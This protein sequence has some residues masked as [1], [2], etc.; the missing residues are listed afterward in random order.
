MSATV[1]LASTHGPPDADSLPASLSAA[2]L[3]SQWIDLPVDRVIVRVGKVELG[4]G[5][6]TALAQIAAEELDVALSRITML[7]ASTGTSPD[8][9]VTSGSR[10]IMDSGSALR[11]VCSQARMLFLIAAAKRCG[12]AAT[13]LSV[14]DGN[15]YDSRG[16]L[17]ASYWQL[18]TADLLA[19]PVTG[20][21]K[22]KPPANHQVVGDSA[23]RLDL[24]DKLAGRPRFIH[25][26]VEPGQL[27]GRVLRPPSPAAHLLELDEG[28][29]LAMP[30]VVRIVRRA[31]FLG[32]IAERE[33]QA[34]QAVEVLR[35]NASWSPQPPLPDQL[36]LTDYLKSQPSQE[37]PIFR[38]PG[39]S[40]I[41][42]ATVPVGG[43]VRGRYTRPYLAHASIAPSAAMARWHGDQVTVWTHSQGIYLLRAAI[44]DACCLAIDKVL[45]KHVEG[46]GCYGHNGA[47]DVA[48]DAVLLAA[49]VPDRPVHVVWS[50]DDEFAWEPYGSAMVAELRVTTDDDGDLVGWQQDI[51]SNGHHSR[52]GYADQPGLLADWHSAEVAAYPPADDPDISVG[53]GI[54]RNGIPAYAIPQ[55]EVTAHRVLTMPLRTSSLRALGAMINVFSIESMMDELAERARVDPL[56]YRLRQLPDERARAVLEAVARQAGWSDRRR[57]DSI[58]W[59]IA[60]ARYKNICAHAAVVARVEALAEVKV[61]NL[62]VVV[63]AGQ[64]INLDGLINQ[65][66]GGAIQATSWTIRERV[67][68]DATTVTSRDWESYPILRFTEVPEVE[69]EVLSRPDEPSLGVGECVAGPV[70]AAIGNALHDAIGVRVRDLPLSPDNIVAAITAD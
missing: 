31:T 47:D 49:A 56:T 27:F 5:I 69:V 22:P 35:A 39:A 52:P 41:P 14:V 53:G 11:W 70:T 64:V 36:R 7:P 29:A 40:G 10:S 46:C 19:H 20:L 18:M 25:D 54:A 45:V 33:E 26:L 9:G 30:G 68:F 1:N 21:V 15:I 4:Q 6:V 42:V 61:Q 8:E 59:G 24:P 37:M 17:V 58:G 63:D 67:S 60:Y 43:E 38:T 62:W 34:I 32:V 13:E 65:I 51:W 57:V 16:D 66:E 50:R 23:P 28:P 12:V 55:L 3:V 44:A 2:P 48:Y